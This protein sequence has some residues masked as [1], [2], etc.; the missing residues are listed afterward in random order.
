M[1]NSK[2]SLRF[3][4]VSFIGVIGSVEDQINDKPF[5]TQI[6]LV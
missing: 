1:W 6:G 5:V 2:S 3:G 4:F